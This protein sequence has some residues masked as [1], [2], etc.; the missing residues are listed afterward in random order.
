MIAKN[1]ISVND[2]YTIEQS[3][4]NLLPVGL[5]LKLVSSNNMP[6]NAAVNAETYSPLQRD[7]CAYFV[8]L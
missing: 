6:S 1:Y 2:I 3:T 5:G 4:S 8:E 7:V